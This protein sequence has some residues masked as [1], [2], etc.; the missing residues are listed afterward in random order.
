[1]DRFEFD[2]H[3]MYEVFQSQDG[4]VGRDLSNR[5][6]RDQLAARR[7]EGKDT[8][9]LERSIV[10]RWDRGR[11]GTGAGRRGDLVAIV[12]SDRWYALLHHEGTRPHVIQPKNPM[13]VLRFVKDGRVVFAR[14]VHHPG[15][16]P[17]RYLSDNLPLAVT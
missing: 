12:G 5:A 1:M 10:K 9:M 16:R 15:T 2:E 14:V 13:G 6:T 3:G 4:E 17:N 8:H 11:V 7:P